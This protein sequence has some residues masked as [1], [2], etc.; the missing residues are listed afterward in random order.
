LKIAAN[1]ESESINRLG[2][3]GILAVNRW[4]AP[5]HSAV[6]LIAQFAFNALQV[7]QRRSSQAE[8]PG[9]V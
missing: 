3:E 6:L 5:P 4:L 7:V 8:H 9:D 1:F 2:E